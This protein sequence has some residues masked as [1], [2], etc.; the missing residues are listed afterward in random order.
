MTFP[1]NK[2]K[3]KKNNLHRC[4]SWLTFS[5]FNYNKWYSPIYFYK[6]SKK[7]S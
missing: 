3:Q 5:I 6:S 2:I 7:N 1:L 4:D